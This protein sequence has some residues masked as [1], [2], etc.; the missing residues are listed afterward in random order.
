MRAYYRS[1]A[2]LLG[3]LGFFFDAM[4]VLLFGL[5]LPAIAR[6][7]T[8]GPEM[9]GLLLSAGTVGMAFG[10]FIGGW[11][12][13]RV[14]RKAIFL[15][16]MVFYGLGTGLTA[17]V[18]SVGVLFLLRFLVG[19]GLG[20]ELPVAATYVFETAPKEIRSRAVVLA[21]S[22]WALGALVA[23]LTARFF[24][25]VGG[26]RAVLAVGALPAF[27]AF[28]ARTRVP[29]SSSQASA[30]RGRGNVRSLLA[31]GLR[32]RT[33]LLWF[34]WIAMNGVYYGL[35]LWLPSLLEA[36]GY[37]I[38]RTFSYI[39]AMNLFQIPGYLTSAWLIETRGRSG[40]LGSFLLG[41]ALAAAAFGF[42]PNTAILLVSGAFL[43][44]FH[45]GAWGALYAYT[46][47]QYPA[48]LRGSGTGVAASWGRVMAAFAPYAVGFF[49]AHGVGQGGLFAIFFG[50]SAAAAAA[51]LLWGAGTRHALDEP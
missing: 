32:G 41:G 22:F 14:S 8:L 37:E 1:S 5:V 9:R 7:W 20:A 10:A 23:A 24:L 48:T 28:L 26:W 45:L 30:D 15:A 29:E 36:R 40:V 33:L 43:N 49:L 3:A 12:A 2:F 4:D 19:I 34:L 13:D 11:I 18:S 46:P 44:F 21:E 16:S 35:F 25:P 50:L 6:E 17:L 42:A 47:E 27:V 51:V 31:R 39:V 38:V